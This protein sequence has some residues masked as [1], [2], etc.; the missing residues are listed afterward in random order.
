MKDDRRWVGWTA[1]ERAAWLAVAAY[2]AV[3]VFPHPLFGHRATVGPVA[4]F[5]D[6]PFDDDALRAAVEG[7][8][9]RVTATG[10]ALPE[11]VEVFLVSGRTRFR[12]LSRAPSRAVGAH[13]PLLD[14]VYLGGVDAA[15]LD[16]DPVRADLRR[17]R[18]E[19]VLAHELV[20]LAWRHELGWL[21]YRRLPW[22]K[23]EGYAEVVAASSSFPEQRGLAL[24]RSG[25][26]DPSTAFRYFEARALVTFLVVDRGLGRAG[27]ASTVH[28]P[29]SLR[30]ALRHRLA[31]PVTL[32]PEAGVNR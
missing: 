17:R 5:S 8:V 4:V 19:D 6:R 27:L 3:V 12:L 14:D 11:R 9:G 15:A 24:I 31:R 10:L 20:H 2:A 7:A 21:A 32:L 18:V 29:R 26:E 1:V 22:W 13:V 16:L 30:A 23:R 28:D 25:R